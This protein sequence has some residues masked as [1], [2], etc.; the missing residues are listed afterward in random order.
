VPY[1]DISEP[2][3]LKLKSAVVAY[4]LTTSVFPKVIPMVATKVSP[5]PMGTL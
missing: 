4:T 3:K 1:Y 5:V 2:N